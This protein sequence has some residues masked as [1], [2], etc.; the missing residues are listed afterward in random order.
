VSA[1]V[2]DAIERLRADLGLI[3][4]DLPGLRDRFAMAALP[5]VQANAHARR[6][7]LVISAHAALVSSRSGAGEVLER[8][9]QIEKDT[10]ESFADIAGRAYAI[11]DAML[12]ERDRKP[13]GAP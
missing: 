1:D 10:N 8:L 11:A 2:E 9:A 4:E 3:A 6:I 7:S 12:A 5:G 13:D